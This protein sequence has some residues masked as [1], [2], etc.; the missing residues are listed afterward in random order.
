MFGRKLLLHKL[1]SHFIYPITLGWAKPREYTY[2]AV[3]TALKQTP[4]PLNIDSHCDIDSDYKFLLLP[5]D[6]VPCLPQFIFSCLLCPISPLPIYGFP[7]YLSFHQTL[8]LC[9]VKPI[10][11]RLGTTYI[12]F[13]RSWTQ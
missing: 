5:V 3:A 2:I 9:R 8:S 7:S 11:C 4:L 13:P 10:Y 1:L 6:P 12:D